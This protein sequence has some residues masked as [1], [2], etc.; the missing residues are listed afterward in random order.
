MP[1][2][3]S[4]NPHF[5]V[6]PHSNPHSWD[7][8]WWT[9]IYPNVKG[10][11]VKRTCLM[12]QAHFFIMAVTCQNNSGGDPVGGALWWWSCGGSH[13][14]FFGRFR[15]VTSNICREVWRFDR[16]IGMGQNRLL[17]YLGNKHPL[18][19]YFRVARVPLTHWHFPRLKLN[20]TLDWNNFVPE[21][22]IWIF[23]PR[24]IPWWKRYG[25]NTRVIA[26]KLSGKRE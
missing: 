2:N 15:V 17:L 16:D 6:I 19:S 3:P 8:F 12:I 26:I 13:H 18:A 14:V 22:G 11:N 4:N 7:E 23:S 25:D 24:G 9:A 20:P 5:G 10:E 21:M 1:S